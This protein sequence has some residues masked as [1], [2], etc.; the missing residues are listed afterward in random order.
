MLNTILNMLPNIIIAIVLVLAGMW[1]GKWVNTMVSGLL[2]RAGFDSV[3]KMGMET[4]TPAKL[5]L[6][7]VVGMIAQ[8]IVILLFTAEALQ[9]VQLHFLVEIAT[10]IIAYLPNVLVAVFILGIGLYAGEL[11]RKVLAS[12]IK[13]QEFKSL[14]AIAK[15]T[16]IAL[17]FFMA[18]DQ[19][20]V[21][22]TIVNSAFII[23]LSGFALAFGLSFGLGGKDFASRYLSTFERKMQ[24]TEIDK[25][26][27]NQNPPNNM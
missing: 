14:A 7:Q 20:G 27:K 3:L 25:N 16:I 10:G 8:I 5:S 22:A 12:I 2:H 9:I 23:V 19:L 26:R 11:V 17:A 13:G 21:A 4:R 24:N 1:A 6:S 18:L 15:Y